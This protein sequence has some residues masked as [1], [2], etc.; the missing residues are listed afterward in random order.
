MNKLISTTLYKNANEISY[1]SFVDEAIIN[2][3]NRV[4][5]IYNLANKK[6]QIILMR[7]TGEMK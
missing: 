4:L 2:F 7:Q 3:T 1:E 6:K 5:Y